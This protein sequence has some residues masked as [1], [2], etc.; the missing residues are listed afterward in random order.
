M[1]QEL[2]A[3]GQP[4][5]RHTA[6]KQD[7]RFANGDEEAIKRITD[8]VEKHIGNIEFVFH[9]IVSDLVHLD[10]LLVSPTK[11]RNYYTLVTCGMS[12][13]PMTVPEGADN[14]KYAELLICLPTNW[15]VS[16]EAFKQEA[17]YWPV[18]LLKQLARLPHE[19]HT[20]LYLAHTIPNGELAQPYAN[21][22]KLSGVMLSTPSIVEDAKQFFSLNSPDG[23]VTHFFSLTPL[24]SEEMDYKLKQGADALLLK[25]NKARVNELLN[26]NRKNVSKKSFWIF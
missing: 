22:T 10:I 9:E 4:I 23:K 12:H 7:L 8:H 2:S 25:L 26:L 19:Y 14:F 3:S 13:L 24:Y 15:Q 1:S 6:G 11:E 18:R 21:N 16:E 5:Y 17:N 20:W